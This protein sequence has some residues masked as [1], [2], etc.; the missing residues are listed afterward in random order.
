[1][2]KEYF[3]SVKQL[4]R[5]QFYNDTMMKKIRETIGEELKLQGCKLQIEACEGNKASFF[6][7]EQLA[8]FMRDGS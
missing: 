5:L 4:L 7:V 2:F 6:P 1:M 8:K 3:S